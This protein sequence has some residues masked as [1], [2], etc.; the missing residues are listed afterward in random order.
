MARDDLELVKRFFEA[1]PLADERAMRL[2]CA[3]DLV[4][5]EDPAWPGA[6][7]YVGWDAV[8]DCWEA[9]G[10]SIGT[11][12]SL[13]VERLIESDGQVVAFVRI[14]GRGS[15]SDIPWEA[16]WGYLVTIV[17]R[18][19]AEFRAFQNPAHALDAVGLRE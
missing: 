6:D 18:R 10:A 16:T 9:Y 8:R 19:V 11:D 13:A 1:L 15:T 7:V 2:L 5:R 12:A 17:N 3:P 14:C 4:Y